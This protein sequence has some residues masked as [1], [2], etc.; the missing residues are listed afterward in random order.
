MSPFFTVTKISSTLFPTP[1]I[2]HQGL[3]QIGVVLELRIH[4]FNVLVVLPEKTTKVDK[5]RSDFLSQNA[6]SFGLVL[7]DSS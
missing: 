7:C 1:L 2:L 6:N 4:H 5:R 3:N